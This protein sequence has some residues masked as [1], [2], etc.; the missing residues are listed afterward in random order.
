VTGCIIHEKQSIELEKNISY[1]LSGHTGFHD[2]YLSGQ[3]VILQVLE[4]PRISFLPAGAFA[5]KGPGKA[6]A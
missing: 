1:N 6:F 5:K 4:T 3:V 2:A